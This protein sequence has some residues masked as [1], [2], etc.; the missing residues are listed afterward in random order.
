MRKNIPIFVI[1]HDFQVQ[2]SGAV[3]Q[4]AQLDR[5]G[6]VELQSGNDFFFPDG[7]ASVDLPEGIDGRNVTIFQSV[8]S[9]DASTMHN[10]IYMLLTIIR[11]YKEY[12]ASN[13]RVFIPYLPYT[14]Q[15]RRIEGERRPLTPKL[16]AELLATSGVDE[17]LSFETGSKDRLVE[18]YRPIELGFLSLMPFYLQVIASKKEKP[19]LIAPDKGAVPTIKKLAEITKLPWS[20]FEKQRLNAEKIVSALSRP[21]NTL[22]HNSALIIDDLICSGSTVES[23]CQ[24]LREVGIQSV[25]VAAAHLRL[26]AKGNET[27]QHLLSTGALGH[28][29]GTDSIQSTGSLDGITLFK[30]E[31]LID[32]KNLVQ[33][34]AENSSRLEVAG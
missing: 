4:L 16:F 33:H 8:I 26:S 24:G 20:F 12:G 28:V 1:C 23:A 17:I 15:D 19:I 34:R 5:L 2:F 3:Q 29:F 27:I 18:L 14:R 25:D 11:T 22:Q 13:I 7:E 6:A 31:E 32:F 9:S 10:N 30:T 21:V